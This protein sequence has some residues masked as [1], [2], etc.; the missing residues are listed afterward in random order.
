[1]Y[2]FL[3]TY[4]WRGC[5][6]T[7]SFSSM[8]LSL[9]QTNFLLL[10]L[11]KYWWFVIHAPSS[12]LFKMFSLLLLLPMASGEFLL[13]LTCACSRKSC[14]VTISSGCLKFNTSSELSRLRGETAWNRIYTGIITSWWGMTKLFCACKLNIDANS[15]KLL[16]F[17]FLFLFNFLLWYLTDL[18]YIL[19]LCVLCITCISMM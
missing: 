15:G 19:Y 5:S 12:D 9:K 13:L 2:I 17:Y 1:M 3:C 6:S 10:N 11:I 4:S 7:M 14:W 16:I 8:G 18:L